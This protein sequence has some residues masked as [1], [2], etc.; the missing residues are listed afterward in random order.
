MIAWLHPALITPKDCIPLLISPCQMLYS[1]VKPLDSVDLREWCFLSPYCSSVSLLFKC[2]PNSHTT[3]P[4]LPFQPFGELCPGDI[5]CKGGLCDPVDKVLAVGRIKED[6]PASS[7]LL[8]S[9]SMG[10]GRIDLTACYLRI[11]EE[12]ITNSPACVVI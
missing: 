8:R 10:E 11:L 2:C 4:I 7:M 3:T 1:P 6:M 5:A 9:E 12:D